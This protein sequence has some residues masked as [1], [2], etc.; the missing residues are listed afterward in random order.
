VN[1]DNS[2]TCLEW[3]PGAEAL[4][5]RGD[6]NDWNRI[7]HPFKKLDF[8]K[9]ELTIPAIDGQPAIKHLS[10]LKLVVLTKS[11]EM[12]DRISPWATYVVQPPK[13]TGNTCYDHVL[14]NPPNDQKY[15]FKNKKPVAPKNLKIYESHV[16]MDSIKFDQYL[17]HFLK[18]VFFIGFSNNF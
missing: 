11:A 14:W 4:F 9:W 15:V 3:C 13:S 6:F 12:A 10:K 2:I 16:G 18:L 5:L 8:G 7:S 1:A 17:R